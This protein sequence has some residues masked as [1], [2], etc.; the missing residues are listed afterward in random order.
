MISKSRTQG[1]RLPIRSWQG[2]GRYTRVRFGS[3]N[4]SIGVFFVGRTERGV[5]SISL[6]CPGGEF[7]RS[8]LEDLG[9]DVFRE[10]G[11][12]EEALDELD[13]YFLGNLMRFSVSVDLRGVTEF[14]RQV[15]L[16]VSNIPFG[17]TVSYSEVAS[18]IGQP[19]AKRAVGSAVGRNPVPIIVPCHRVVA[20]NG[21]LGGFSAGLEIKRALLNIEGVRMT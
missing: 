9:M 3:L 2:S 14:T 10:Q 4:T 1:H 19:L 18:Q 21:K 15:L 11:A 20:K 13:A 5:C 17:R 8:E 16:R 6:N 12:V 7:Y